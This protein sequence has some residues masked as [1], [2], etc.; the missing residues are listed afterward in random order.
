MNNQEGVSLVNTALGMITTT[1]AGPDNRTKITQ[2]EALK[3]PKA[4]PPNPPP[5]G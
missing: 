5:S 3:G 1:K 2:L 4:L